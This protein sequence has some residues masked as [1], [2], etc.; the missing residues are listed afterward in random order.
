M[1]LREHDNVP[2]SL[3]SPG[4]SSLPTEAASQPP[5]RS[6]HVPQVSVVAALWNNVGKD[7]RRKSSEFSVPRD[8]PSGHRTLRQQGEGLL[9]GTASFQAWLSRGVSIKE[10]CYGPCVTAFGL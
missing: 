8:D 1:G 7:V 3:V 10:G 9:V 4:Q 5:G 2:T 6:P